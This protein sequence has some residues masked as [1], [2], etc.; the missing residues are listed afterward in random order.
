MERMVDQVEERGLAE[1]LVRVQL[2]EM[3]EE[4]ALVVQGAEPEVEVEQERLEQTL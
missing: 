4:M 2:E 1:H 3:L